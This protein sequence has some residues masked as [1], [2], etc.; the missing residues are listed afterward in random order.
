MAGGRPRFLVG[1]GWVPEVLTV[2]T[3]LFPHGRNAGPIQKVD[4]ESGL[5]DRS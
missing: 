1:A 5:R 4:A 2:S 3:D